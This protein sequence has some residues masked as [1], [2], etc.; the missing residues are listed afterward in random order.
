[1]ELSNNFILAEFIYF[2][3]NIKCGVL[4]LSLVIR[5]K[6]Y[7]KYPKTELVTSGEL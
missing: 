4:R 7:Y 2:V 5:V 6:S 3:M 1:M